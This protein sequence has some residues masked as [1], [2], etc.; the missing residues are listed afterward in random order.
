MKNN[1][2]VFLT[3]ATGFV[4]GHLAAQLAAAGHRTRCLVRRP[5]HRRAAYLKE[6]GAELATGD[7]LDPDALRAAIEGCGAVVHLVGI[8]VETTAATFE[9]IHV[10]GTK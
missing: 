4:G 8:I 2:P 9:Q 7:I 3:G 5:D 10:Q 6:L 1:A